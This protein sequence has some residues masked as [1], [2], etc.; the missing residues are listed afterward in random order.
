MQSLGYEHEQGWNECVDV[1]IGIIVD[2]LAI[3]TTPSV[4]GDD[5]ASIRTCES[6][7]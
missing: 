5:G 2:I 3:N 4:A 7:R 6:L 1:V